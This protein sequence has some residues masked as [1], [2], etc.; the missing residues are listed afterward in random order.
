VAL[1]E[2]LDRIDTMTRQLQ[3][4]WDL[5]FNGQEKKPPSDLQSQLE[6]LLKRYA[7]SEIR[8]NGERFRYQSLSARYTTFNELWQKRLRAR[9]EGKAFGVHG[10]RADQL[11][12]P[13]PGLPKPAPA[14]A[15]GRPA[16]APGEI[17]V[18]DAAR[19]ADAVQELYNRFVEERIRAGE[20]HAPH[21]ENFRDLIRQQTE[22]IRAEKGAQAV[23]FR[24]ETRD[25]KVSLKARIVK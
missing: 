4:K 19:D 15:A 21:F 1:S 20:A 18:A 24:L 16:P 5:F 22:R 25:G 12:P 23:D 9:E 6:T 3:V 11:P 13:R 2:D 8:N 17:R 7:N 14:P 10:L